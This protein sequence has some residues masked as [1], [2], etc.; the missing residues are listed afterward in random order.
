MGLGN[1]PWE[2]K[3]EETWNSRRPVPA[4]PI[5][6]MCH[7]VLGSPGYSL[8]S[9]FMPCFTG[10]WKQGSVTLGITFPNVWLL[11][12]VQL[13]V[14]PWTVAYEAPLSMGF[15]RQ[16][17]WIG[18]P[19]P[20]PGDLPDPGMNPGLLH[21]GKTLYPLS[22][23]GS[24]RATQMYMAK[25]WFEFLSDTLPISHSSCFSYTNQ[26]W[27]GAEK[28]KEEKFKETKRELRKEKWVNS[29]DSNL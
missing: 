19:F 27:V 11:S 4:L 6:F 17:Y 18:L 12:C 3:P 22:H 26:R 15:S 7:T 28:E 25:L 16:E 9:S 20:S 24:P 2:E 8:T 29:K 5:A 14:T 1:G 13:L 23:Q 10:A 21:C